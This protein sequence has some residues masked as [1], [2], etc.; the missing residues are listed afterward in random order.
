MSLILL[1]SHVVIIDI[2]YL[3]QNHMVSNIYHDLV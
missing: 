1:A 3:K 2:Y